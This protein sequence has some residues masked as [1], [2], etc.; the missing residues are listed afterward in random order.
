MRYICI[1][2]FVLCIKC[3][4]E[5][6]QEI[7]SGGCLCE[8][9]LESGGENQEKISFSLQVCMDLSQSSFWLHP[10]QA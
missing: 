8:G 7:Y 10:A 5:D 2:M 4:W 6:S 1:Y 3:L 9:V